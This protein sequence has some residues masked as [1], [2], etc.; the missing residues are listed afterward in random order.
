MDRR[1]TFYPGEH[2]AIVPAEL[3][4][5]AQQR[6]TCNRRRQLGKPNSSQDALLA[7]LLFDEAG[8]P[9]NPT[10]NVKS[11]G[12]TYRYRYYVSQT[13]LR[14]DAAHGFISPVSRPAIGEHI[15]K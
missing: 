4:E 13:K 3:F 15:I 11:D 14:S 2:K 6:L 10:Y 1:N 7:G 12:R 9:M 8:A 5:A